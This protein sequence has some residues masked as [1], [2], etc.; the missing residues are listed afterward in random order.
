MKEIQRRQLRGHLNYEILKTL[1]GQVAGPILAAELYRY[2]K[3][4]Q[5][6][7]PAQF[8]RLLSRREYF[9][10]YL[11][12]LAR[13]GTIRIQ[14]L[15]RQK[16]VVLTPAGKTSLTELERSLGRS[17]LGGSRFPSGDS[18][19]REATARLRRKLPSKNMRDRFAIMRKALSRATAGKD[20]EAAF[21]SYDIPEFLRRDRYRVSRSLVGLGFIQLNGSFYVGPA[22]RLPMA[23]E[24]IE[25]LG[26]LPYCCWGAIR[27]LPP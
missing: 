11:Y 24:W 26:L 25:D 23:I 5:A 16:R 14:G 10:A 19:I 7:T 17:K 20:G 27:L 1:A 21:V 6:R 22:G 3:L 2:V 13:R 12:R 15:R 4:G 18:T 8:A 9:Y